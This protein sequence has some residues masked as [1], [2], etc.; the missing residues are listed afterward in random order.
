[1]ASFFRGTFQSNPFQQAIEKVTDENQPAEDWSL[2]MRICDHVVANEESAKEAMKGIRK[3]LQ[4]TPVNK[5][6]NAIAYTLTLLEALTKN[7]GRI[8]HLQLTQ[9]DFLKELKN[10]IEP[11]NNPPP[12]IQDKILGLIQTW[13]LAFRNDPELKSIE[14][15]YNECKQQGLEFPPAESESTIKAAVPSTGTIERPT[16]STPN[17]GVN[18]PTVQARTPSDA[19][20]QQVVLR[21]MTP[22]QLAKL[23]SEL[24]VVQTNGQVF[25]EMLITLQPGE[26]HP[27][28]LE[29]LIELN[30][31]CRQIQ[32]RIVELLSQ[33]SID[34]ITVDL[35]RYNDEFNNSFKTFDSYMEERE[36]RVGPRQL[37]QAASAATSQNTISFSPTS[38]TNPS[39]PPKNQDNEPALIKFDDDSSSLAI[40]LRNT[41]INSMGSDATPKSPQHQQSTA[42]VTTRPVVNKTNQDVESDVKEVEQWLN[43]QNTNTESSTDTSD[44]FKEFLEKRASTIS[45][46]PAADQQQSQ[47][48][49]PQPTNNNPNA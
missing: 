17:P 14:Q 4:V 12:H 22:D 21:Q 11:K 23:R 19:S 16:R 35:L 40:N 15:F 26:E 25:G 32:S 39:S 41:H 2:I 48:H 43:I 20:G 37:N 18:L 9:K 44:A 6:W 42:S 36:R 3:R 38:T 31:T 45:D 47:F 8:F 13:A 24:D 33:V 7:C 46:E 5:G 30:K 34:E 49:I 1:M 29:F 27:Q 28:D 10:I